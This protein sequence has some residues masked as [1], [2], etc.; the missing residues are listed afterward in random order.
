MAYGGKP[1]PSLA[2]VFWSV[3]IW[4]EGSEPCGWIFAIGVDPNSERLGVASLLLAE[5]VARFKAQGVPRIRTMVRRNDVPVLAFFR[6][7]GFRG[8][9]FVQLELDIEEVS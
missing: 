6:S 1:L 7:N 8:G 3:R 5:A 9:P 4:A 2:R